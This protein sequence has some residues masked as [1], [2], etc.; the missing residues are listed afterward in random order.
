MSPCSSLGLS[1]E[2]EPSLPRLLCKIAFCTHH[3]QDSHGVLELNRRCLRL[4]TDSRK[5][6]RRQWIQAVLSVTSKPQQRDRQEASLSSLHPPVLALGPHFPLWQRAPG[7]PLSFNDHM[8]S[9]VQSRMA[10][11]WWWLWGWAELHVILVFHKRPLYTLIWSML[12]PQE[13]NSRLVLCALTGS[14]V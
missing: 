11:A 5:N 2:R 8:F 7:C 12:L 1:E 4:R 6:Q 14:G 13:E 9:A 10:A 3:L